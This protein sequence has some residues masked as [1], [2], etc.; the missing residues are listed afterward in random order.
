LDSSDNL[1][2]STFLDYCRHA[3]VVDPKILIIIECEI[4]KRLLLASK[5]IKTAQ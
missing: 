2:I 1:A 4:K 3:D 5:S